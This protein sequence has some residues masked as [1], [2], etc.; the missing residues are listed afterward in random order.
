MSTTQLESQAQFFVDASGNQ[1]S[2]LLNIHVWRQL[3]EIL[4]KMAVEANRTVRP[5]TETVKDDP[6]VAFI[7]IASV[8]PFA[9][10]ADELLYGP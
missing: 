1:T 9:D 10:K 5:I 3:I 2:V 7:G 8:E 6:L 4:S